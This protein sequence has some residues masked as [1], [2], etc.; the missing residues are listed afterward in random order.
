MKNKNVG[1]LILGI[2]V[3]LA[4]IVF[5]FNNALNGIVS[6][7]CSHGPSCTMYGT[8]KVQTYVSIALALL[9]AIIGL[10][11]IFSRENERI[12]IKKERNRQK[13]NKIDY[14]ILNKEER[15]LIKI[16]EEAQ[17]AIFQSDL[18]EKSGF[19]KVKVSRVLDKL[20]GKQIVERKRRG[21]T[22]VV[23]LNSR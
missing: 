17:N 7:S 20:E 3:V 9:I 19:D 15:H 23:L 12:I 10:F 5:L 21:M 2:A 11:L 16:I 8:I 14:S 1:F 13:E 6:Q 4:I 18:V 22:N